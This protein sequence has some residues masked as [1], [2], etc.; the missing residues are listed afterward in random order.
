MDVQSQV[1]LIILLLF[2]FL[3]WGRWRYDGVTLTALA[4]MVLRALLKGI[5]LLVGKFNEK[6]EG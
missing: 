5:K 1:A 4:A 3:V 6:E 2:G